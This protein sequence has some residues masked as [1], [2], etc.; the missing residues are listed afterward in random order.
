MLVSV[1]G[2]ALRREA[3]SLRP[4]AVVPHR[5]PAIVCAER[6]SRWRRLFQRGDGK[7]EEAGAAPA[8]VE[9]LAPA[10]E[11]AAPVE[12]SLIARADKLHAANQPEELFALLE[13]ADVSDV[14]LAWRV[15]RCYHDVAEESVDDDARR[16]RLIREG[17]AIAE[18]ALEENPG[19]GPVTKWVAILLGRLGDF[20]PTKEKVG[21]L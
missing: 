11:E 13:G 12:A 10:A 7:V 16:E 4:A 6:K 14:E 2:P 20:L 15:A 5:V 8:A 19:Y 17:L 1:I 21:Q 3:I 9:M 18:V